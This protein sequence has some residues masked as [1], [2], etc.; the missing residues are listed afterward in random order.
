MPPW[1]WPGTRL[2]GTSRLHPVAAGRAPPA[3][4]VQLP[5]A[6]QARHRSLQHM[7][8]SP[9]HHHLQS[10]AAMNAKASKLQKPTVP[11]SR[12]PPRSLEGHEVGSCWESSA[13]NGMVKPSR[14][15]R[16][17]VVQA[18]QRVHVEALAVD[19]DLHQRQ[20]RRLQP[21]RRWVSRDVRP[22]LVLRQK[23]RIRGS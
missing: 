23:A 4:Q 13:R 10:T 2:G 22:P 11:H 20:P 12:T 21:Q 19:Q 18:L 8:S 17:D 16:R 5:L 9:K 6:Q 7:L 14:H 15:G 3:L 1:R